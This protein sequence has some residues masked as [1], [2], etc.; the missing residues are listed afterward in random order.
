M[1]V[2]ITGMGA[3]SPLGMTARESFSRRGSRATAASPRRS[4]F[5]HEITQIFA[6][7]QV[8]DFTPEP[9]VNKREAKRMA[10]F[11]Q[12]A[13]VAAAQAW[14]ESG[15]ESRRSIDPDRVGVVLGSGMGGLDVICE[16]YAELDQ[17]WAQERFF[18]LY[19]ES[20]HQHDGG[21]DCDPLRAQRPV[22]F[23]RD[24]LRLRRGRHRARVLRRARR[25]RG[26]D[27]R[28]RCGIGDESSSRCRA[29]IRWAR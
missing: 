6:A 12:M 16:Q 24:R 3:V 26:R 1:K 5:L 19:P 18:V 9:Y 23:H 15:L 8:K 29:S 7:G 14:E 10:R 27:A 25:Q 21:A 13:I 20:D 4:C 17:Q 28:R 11:T 2:Y 22:L